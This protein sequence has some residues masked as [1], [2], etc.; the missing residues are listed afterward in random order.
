MFFFKYVSSLEVNVCRSE[1]D[2]IE[3]GSGIVLTNEL[4]KDLIICLNSSNTS[5]INQVLLKANRSYPVPRP[6]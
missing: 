5:I 3:E 2:R 4:F 1:N 6:H